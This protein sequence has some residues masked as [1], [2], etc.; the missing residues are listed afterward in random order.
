MREI[1]NFLLFLFL[2]S[3]ATY[4]QKLD[5]IVIDKATKTPMDLA[6]VFFRTLKYTIF[7]NFE[8]KFSV[9][10]DLHN[11]KD[12]LIISCIGYDDLIFN[13]QEFT[14]NK[15]YEKVFEMVQKAQQLEEIVISNETIDYGWAK[16]INS[17]RK[18]NAGFSF[19]FGTE[20]VRL[21]QNP[22]FKNGKVNKVILSLDKL[23]K[24]KDNPDWKMDYITAY[25]IK[26]Y[27]YDA[28]NQKPGEELYNENIV[29][30]P[31]NKTYDFV[32]DV[33]S[34]NIPF[35][36]DGVC[37]GIEYLN[38]RYL[39]PKMNSATVGPFMNFYQEEKLKPVLAWTRYRGIDWEFK[40]L[41]SNFK[42]RRYQN[43][44]VVDLIVNTENKLQSINLY[45]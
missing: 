43:V 32:I 44:L 11:K 35:P 5:G 8:G 12:A 21:V 3:S 13:L 9:E 39:N 4:S 33:D 16:S 37:V 15:S 34:L 23:K 28:R 42:N 27:K 36:K 7:T 17:K 2:F 25:N 31:E 14:F 1:R 45:P 22:Y 19:Q 10:I 30:Q 38:T 18:P 29:V 40:S 41:I 6:S 24:N 26:F 20:N